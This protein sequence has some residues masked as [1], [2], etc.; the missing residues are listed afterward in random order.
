MLAAPRRAHKSLLLEVS[1]SHFIC[2]PYLAWDSSIRDA[3]QHDPVFPSEPIGLGRGGIIDEIAKIIVIVIIIVLGIWYRISHP[4]GGRE[5][6]IALQQFTKA[7][8]ATPRRA[9]KSLHLEVSH[10][11]FIYCPYL[12]WDSSTR[13]AL[14]HIL[15]FPH[16][17]SHWPSHWGQRRWNSASTIQGSDAR[18]SPACTQIPSSS[19]RS[20]TASSY[21]VLIW[22]GT[23]LSVM[24]CSMI[25]SSRPDQSDSTEEAT[26]MGLRKS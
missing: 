26:L 10:N 17:V 6:G 19:S 20:R 9:H 11:H 12:A 18:S 16:L 4:T 7:M 1:H 8:F 3:L 23:A 14:Q 5:G 21:A 2:C 25:Q 15:V 22:H 24:L 13:D